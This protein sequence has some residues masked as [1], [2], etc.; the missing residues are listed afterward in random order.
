MRLP[1]LPKLPQC[2]CSDPLNSTAISAIQ[3][4]QSGWGWR[5]GNATAKYAT[6]IFSEIIDIVG[7][8][9]NPSNFK[10][11]ISGADVPEELSQCHSKWNCQKAWM[12]LV[13]QLVLGVWFGTLRRLRHDSFR[14]LIEI[15]YVQN[16]QISEKRFRSCFPSRAHGEMKWVTGR[17][18]ELQRGG[19]K[20]GKG[21]PTERLTQREWQ[22]GR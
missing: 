1:A 18:N 21:R 16:T 11:H 22:R 13:F 9:R 19:N 12:T 15:F 2:C 5:R 8:I 17:R 3:F 4:N 6:A 7:L 10:T 20:K 14:C